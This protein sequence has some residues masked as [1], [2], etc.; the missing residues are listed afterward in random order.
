MMMLVLKCCIMGRMLL[1]DVYAKIEYF[2][3]SMELVNCA[4]LGIVLVLRALES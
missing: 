4:T 1:V 3:N 2:A